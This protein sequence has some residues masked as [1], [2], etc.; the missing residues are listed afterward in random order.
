MSSIVRV[1]FPIDQSYAILFE[2]EHGLEKIGII[3]QNQ[4]VLILNRGPFY[5]RI[6][7][8]KGQLGWVDTNCLLT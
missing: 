7:N 6:L 1:K 2:R 8:E 5:S 4:Y 3:H